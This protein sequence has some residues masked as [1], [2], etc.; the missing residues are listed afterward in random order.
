MMKYLKYLLVPVLLLLFIAIPLQTKAQYIPKEEVIVAHQSVTL[1]LPDA[2]N[3]TIVYRPG[4]NISDTVRVPVDSGTYNWTPREAG[5]VTLKSSNGPQQTVSVRFDEA[6]FWGFFIMFGAAF[7][8]FGGAL[9][10]SIKLF[11]KETPDEIAARPD[12]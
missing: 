8:L 9:F 2:K 10:A 6:P 5:I 3:L 7:I 1:T 11:G 4:S 12:T